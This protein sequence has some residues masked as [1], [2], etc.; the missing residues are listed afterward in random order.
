MLVTPGGVLVARFVGLF[1]THRLNN[2]LIT[3][4]WRTIWPAFTGLIFPPLRSYSRSYFAIHPCLP[5][6][7]TANFLRNDTHR[8]TATRS[9]WFQ[10]IILAREK[11]EKQNAIF[12][13][14]VALLKGRRIFILLLLS[15]VIGLAL[16]FSLKKERKGKTRTRKQNREILEGTLR[17]SRRGKEIFYSCLDSASGGFRF[18][19]DRTG[20]LSSLVS[21]GI[22]KTMRHSDSRH[23][24]HVALFSG[25][26]NI[27]I[28]VQ[29]LG[30]R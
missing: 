21:E 26:W 30:D 22:D 28:N 5:L 10:S 4:D 12:F 14:C 25:V 18:K 16:T 9:R 8:R 20:R 29:F 7:W 23:P 2:A 6:V 17:E 13:H 3:S 24:F 11:R 19:H 1:C 27:C 15:Y